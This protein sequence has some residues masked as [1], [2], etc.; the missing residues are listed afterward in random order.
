MGYRIDVAFVV[1]GNSNTDK[2]SELLALAKVAGIDIEAMDFGTLRVN[3]TDNT[4]VFQVY[5]TKWY[6]GYD[7]VALVN[8]FM[9]F[10]ADTERFSYRF[11]RI[12]EELEDNEVMDQGHNP[13][14]ECVGI[15]RS[16]TIDV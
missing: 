3:D 13:P 2:I 6:D 4:L 7:D 10:A 9:K 12:G 11:V 16:I 8:A 5:D 14:Y 1:R 15:T